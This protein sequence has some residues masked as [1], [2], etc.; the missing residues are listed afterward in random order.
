MRMRS[1]FCSFVQLELR[2]S[3]TYWKRQNLVQNETDVQNFEN[4]LIIPL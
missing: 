4:V 1:I 2:M 3:K